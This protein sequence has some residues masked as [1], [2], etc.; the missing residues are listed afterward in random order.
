MIKMY[1]L[2]EPK[3]AEHNNE[4]KYKDISNDSNKRMQVS[5]M[6]GFNVVEL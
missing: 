3:V 2:N 1:L 5:V 4:C 6:N